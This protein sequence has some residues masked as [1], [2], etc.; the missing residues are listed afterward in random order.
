MVRPAQAVTAARAAATPPYDGPAGARR[1]LASGGTSVGGLAGP[2]AGAA[3]GRLGAVSGRAGAP[4]HFGSSPFHFGF[5]RARRRRRRT[6]APAP[7][8]SSSTAAAAIVAM[9]GGACS[10]RRSPPMPG[11]ST[12]IF[13]TIADRETDRK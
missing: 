1:T 2:A 3:A 8:K 4:F 10:V 7:P 11:A 6:S 9:I 5:G 13:P 12:H